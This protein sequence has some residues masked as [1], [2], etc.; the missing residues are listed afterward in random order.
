MNLNPYYYATK[1]VS[2]NNSSRFIYID[3]RWGFEVGEL[4]EF[5][6]WPLG[7]PEAKYMSTRKITLKG[8]S[9]AVTINSDWGFRDKDWVTYRMR[10]RPSEADGADA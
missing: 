4:V 5:E 7:N 2:R 9:R 6:V 1:K 3:S 10:R 8:K